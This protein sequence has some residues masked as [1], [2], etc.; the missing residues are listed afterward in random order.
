[1]K[2]EEIHRKFDLLKMKMK[3]D[4]D[5]FMG[6]RNAENVAFNEAKLTLIDQQ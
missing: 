1:M 6:M 2:R 5:F 4:F 3:S